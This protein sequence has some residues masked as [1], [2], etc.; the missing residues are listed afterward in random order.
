MNPGGFCP[1]VKTL[2]QIWM[3]IFWGVIPVEIFVLV[4]FILQVASRVGP[5]AAGSRQSEG[6]QAL[7]GQMCNNQQKAADV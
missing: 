5:L 1:G 4:I 7:P 3:W 2:K 6:S